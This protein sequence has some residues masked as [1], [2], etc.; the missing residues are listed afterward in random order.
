LPKTGKNF[1]ALL[2]IANFAEWG[3]FAKQNPG[4]YYFRHNY[5]P[6]TYQRLRLN[7]PQLM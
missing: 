2:K 3:Y 4:Y 1:L 5:S 6:A 7:F